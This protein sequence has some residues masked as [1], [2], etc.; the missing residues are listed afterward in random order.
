MYIR[1]YMKR[2]RRKY[3]NNNNNN[4]YYYNIT[5][6]QENDTYILLLSINHIISFTNILRILSVLRSWGRKYSYPVPL[7]TFASIDS[8]TFIS[9]L[10]HIVFLYRSNLTK[11]K[12]K[13]KKKSSVL[14]FPCLCSLFPLDSFH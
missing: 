2:N 7:N 3:D 1:I 6:I 5:R 14:P 8:L 10:C 12:L 9:A 11:L 4:N 13:K